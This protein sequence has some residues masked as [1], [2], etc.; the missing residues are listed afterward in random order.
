MLRRPL[1]GLAAA[2]LGRATSDGEWRPLTAGR[3]LGA[4]KPREG[5]PGVSGPGLAFR[6]PNPPRR[7]GEHSSSRVSRPPAPAPAERQCRGP[8]SGTHSCAR[9]LLFTSHP[10]CPRLP[11]GLQRS[12]LERASKAGDTVF[13][14][15]IFLWGQI[16]SF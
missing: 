6:G 5:F 13:R 15:R 1:A 14:E 9:A 8:S 7:G 16:Y 2:A 10:N 4:C 11:S 12:I 3:G